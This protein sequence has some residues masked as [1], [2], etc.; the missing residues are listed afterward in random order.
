MHDRAGGQNVAQ[1]GVDPVKTRIV[2]PDLEQTD[3]NPK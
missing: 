1:Y 2:T 3:H